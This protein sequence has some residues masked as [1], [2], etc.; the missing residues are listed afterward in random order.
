MRT[1]FLSDLDGTL[2]NDNGVLSETTKCILTKLLRE[3]LDFT[4]ASGRTPLSVGPLFQEIPLRL[5]MILMNGALILN[6]VDARPMETTPLSAPA[7]MLLAEAEV[8]LRLHGLLFGL[9]HDDITMSLVGEPDPFWQ[10][11]FRR[12][13]AERAKLSLC[14]G[15]AGEWADKEVLYGIYIDRRP[16]R[17]VQLRD[18]LAESSCF[19]LDFYRDRYDPDTWCLE[20]YSAQA[21]K[22]WA[23]ERVRAITGVNH[24]VGFGDSLN[25]L[26]LFRACEET[27]AVANARDEVKVAADAVI[28]SHLEDG[29]VRYLERRWRDGPIF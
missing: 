24:M 7:R 23:A 20:L 29:V 28:A 8:R 16:E 25:D 2:L 1:L 21:S 4:I 19:E 11:F 6:P 22:R 10:A 12:N 9:E 15:G 17:L 3:G 18:C 14:Q 5:P 26:P 27:Y 13:H